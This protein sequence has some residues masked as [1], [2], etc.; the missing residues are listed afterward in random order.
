MSA[1]STV[2]SLVVHYSSAGFQL[3]DN[4]RVIGLTTLR[5]V[6]DLRVISWMC[7]TR[8]ALPSASK[9]ITIE[10]LLTF[11]CVLRP[12]ILAG[13]ERVNPQVQHQLL[14]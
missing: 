10:W 4:L 5:S 3:T 11:A 7:L 1:A 9:G 2:S 8:E 13:G 12:V 14:I 6:L